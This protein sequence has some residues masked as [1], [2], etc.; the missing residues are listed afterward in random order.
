M[1]NIDGRHDVLA[2]SDQTRE[3]GQTLPAI[4]DARH[5]AGQ[6][7]GRIHLCLASAS[8]PPQLE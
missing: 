8:K 5:L 6:G 3:L 2:L 7:F 1:G 4:D